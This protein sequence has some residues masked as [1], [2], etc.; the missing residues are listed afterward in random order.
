MTYIIAGVERLVEHLFWEHYCAQALRCQI[1]TADVSNTETMPSSWTSG[2]LA[3]LGDNAYAVSMVIE[4]MTNWIL[5][6][7]LLT[8]AANDVYVNKEFDNV[9]FWLQWSHHVAPQI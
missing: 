9:A 2:P 5:Q 8:Y 1:T 3:Q 7:G 6:V 4:T